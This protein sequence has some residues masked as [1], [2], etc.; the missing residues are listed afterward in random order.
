[1]ILE[2]AVSLTDYALA[3]ESAVLAALLWRKPPS[4]ARNWF[5]A[6]FA[7]IGIAAALG[8]TVHGF[9]ANEST[10]TY[11]VL[12]RA[13]L[14][15]IGGVALTAAMAAASS[16]W[17]RPVQ[18][19]VQSIAAAGFV[20]YSVAVLLF[21]QRYLAAIVVYLPATLF[22]L[23]SFVAAY[24]RAAGHDRLRALSGASGMLLTLVAAGVQQSRI[25]IARLDHNALY[26]I[27]QA[28]ALLLI[29]AG[30]LGVVRSSGPAPTK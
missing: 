16:D 22:L 25:E 10:R 6:F 14:I 24:F 18:R 30:A 26:H 4:A 23:A 8:G 3:L 19:I 11:A 15:S 29:Y 9:V 28:V 12:W 27:I 1:M 5:V 2:P 13:T 21:T 17:S 7:L 20:V